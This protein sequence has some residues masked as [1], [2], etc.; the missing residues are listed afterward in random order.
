LKFNLPNKEKGTLQLSYEG[1]DNTVYT[2]T[3]IVTWDIPS[4]SPTWLYLII[5][6]V[7]AYVIWKKKWYKK[8][9]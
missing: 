5:I 7:V 9:L 1:P 8:I 3:E 2:Q 4:S 6:I